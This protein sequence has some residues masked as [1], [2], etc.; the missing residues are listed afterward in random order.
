MTNFE[1]KYF[2]K[3]KF[4]EDQVRRYLDNALRDLTIADEDLHSEVKFSYAYSALIKSGIALLAAKGHVKV[5]ST[6]GH[7][8]KIIEKMAALLGD[9]SVLTIGNAMRMKRN[10]DFYGGGIFVSE[11]ESGEYLNFVEK[12]VQKIK[13]I[14]QAAQRLR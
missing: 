4:T 2:T 12:V 11:K 7:H 13:T 1:A 6:P 10:E 9:E 14:I 3:F 5:R 8:V